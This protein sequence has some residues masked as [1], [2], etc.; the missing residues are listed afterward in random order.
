MI[1]YSTVD[2]YSN[3][4][5][6]RRSSLRPLTATVIASN[7]TIWRYK[8]QHRLRLNGSYLINNN[9][10]LQ[11]VNAFLWPKHLP[12]QLSR[13]CI[14]LFKLRDAFKK[15]CSWT[16]PIIAYLFLIQTTVKISQINS[17]PSTCRIYVIVFH[18][19]FVFG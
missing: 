5:R 12:K 1:A 19:N 17:L 7:E 18:P 6:I 11:Q 13:Y 15:L 4:R 3:I 2:N 16:G 10:F 14:Y 9:N 8:I